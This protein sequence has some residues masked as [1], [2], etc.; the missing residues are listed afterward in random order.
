MLDISFLVSGFFVNAIIKAVLTDANGVETSKAMQIRILD[1]EIGIPGFFKAG[2]VS[3][4]QLRSV[5]DSLG[6]IRHAYGNEWIDYKVDVKH[7]GLYDVKVDLKVQRSKQYGG[8]VIIKSGTHE[9]GRFTT[10]TNDPDRD[11]LPGFTE[12]PNAIIRNVQ[13]SAGIQTIRVTFSHPLGIVKPQF[14]L[15][16]FKFMKQG[17]PDISFTSPVKNAADEYGSYDAPASIKI[18]GNV[19]SSRAD[20]VVKTA[21]LYMNDVLVK[22]LSEPPYIWNDLEEL[23]MMNDV[24]DGD[25]IF[26]IEATDELGYTSFEEINLHVIA[27]RPYNP[28]LKIPGVVKAW[29][30]DMGGEGIGYHDF[31]EGLERGLGGEQN[32]RYAKAG[33]EDAE[34]EMSA[35]DYCVSGIRSGEWLSYTISDVKKGIYDIILTT[36]ANAGKSADV[37]VWLNNKII[38]TVHTTQTGSAFSVY[39]DFKTVNI[40]IPR[41]LKNANIRL[42]FTHPTIRNYLCFFRKFEFKKTGDVANPVKDV[43]KPTVTIFPNPANSN[44]TIDLGSISSADIVV[45]DITGKQVLMLHGVTTKT[46]INK[47]QLLDIGTYFISIYTKDYGLITHKLSML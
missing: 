36:S 38:G 18:A 43:L 41:D 40:E 44:F 1:D 24:T 3:N 10:I 16:S 35:G 39:K 21:S 33:N 23:E 46:E 15:Y 31:N 2:E 17:A 25:Y 34:I 12:N 42:E 20:G 37:K 32:P 22:T 14:Y 30:F 7:A 47:S 45:R 19:T 29:E 4:Y 8:A 11:A 28:N 9:L 6:Y 27:R 13:L 5:P 26:K